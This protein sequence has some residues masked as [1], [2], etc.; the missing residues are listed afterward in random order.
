M[1]EESVLSPLLRLQSFHVDMQSVHHLGLLHRVQRDCA[2]HFFVLQVTREGHV[3]AGVVVQYRLHLE[4]ERGSLLIITINKRRR[5][6]NLIIPSTR[7]SSEFLD[8]PSH[9]HVFVGAVQV[10]Q[11]SWNVRSDCKEINVV[12]KWSMG[13]VN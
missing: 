4:G 7:N 10:L 5:R 11:A 13:D 8:T 6:T 12:S 3:A 2:V 1:Q 9:F